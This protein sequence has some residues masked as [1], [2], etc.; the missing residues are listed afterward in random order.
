MIN[1]GIIG[2]GRSGGELHATPLQDMD[3]Y[4]LVAVSAPNVVRLA[5][6]GVP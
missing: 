4:R 2:L 1:V 3:D 5:Q 6:A